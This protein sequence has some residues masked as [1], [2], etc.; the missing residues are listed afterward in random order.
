MGKTG[1]DAFGDIV[2]ETLRSYGAH[3]GLIRDSE[4]S[5]SY[6]VVL[7][8]PGIDRIFL[9]HPGANHDFSAADIP[10]SRWRGQQYST[11][12]TRL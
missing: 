7:A 1:R 2:E 4:A 5:T 3:Q 11:S 8:I 12:A 6:T 10:G 9:H